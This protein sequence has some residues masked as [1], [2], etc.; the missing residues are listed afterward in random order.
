MGTRE[1][2]VTGSPDGNAMGARRSTA[3]H[4]TARSQAYYGRDCSRSVEGQGPTR[5]QQAFG[6][7]MEA[8][9]TSNT[10]N[11]RKSLANKLQRA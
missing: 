11:A 6:T 9:R 5:H 2:R 4:A 7:L 3:D 10:S 8:V 1:T